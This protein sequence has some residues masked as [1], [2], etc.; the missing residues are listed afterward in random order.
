MANEYLDKDGLKR[1]IELVK[2]KIAELKKKV[3]K[4]V[5][6]GTGTGAIQQVPDGVADG[7][8]FTDK[9]PTATAYGPY[10][11]NDMKK[12]RYL[13]GNLPYG[14]VGNYSSAFG[15]KCLAKGKRSH[16][17]GTTTVS[18]GDY[19]HVEGN[20][21]VTLGANSHAEGKQ[22]TTLGENAHAE[23]FDSFAEG[24][25]SHA[26]GYKTHSK[27]VAS[28]AQ[29]QETK[30]LGDQ[31]SASGYKTIAEGD[32][33]TAQGFG[34]HAKGKCSFVTGEGTIAEY[35]YQTV[36]GRYNVPVTFMPI[37]KGGRAEVIFIVGNGFG[38][39][40]RDNAMLVLDNGEIVTRYIG[41]PSNDNC[42]INLRQFYDLIAKETA[43][44]LKDGN[45]IASVQGGID[46]VSGYKCDFVFGEGL[47]NT[48][49]HQTVFGRF[50]DASDWGPNRPLF[51][52]GNGK[53]D[54]E[55]S[56]AFEVRENGDVYAGGKKLATV[57]EIGDIEAV[58]DSVIALQNSLIGGNV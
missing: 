58:L 21:S 3:P 31:S 34:T 5:E 1:L 18:L 56:N 29:G 22:T 10:I 42:L 44:N 52:I 47:H 38:D 30:A 45:G 15:G 57:D 41:T 36:V 50:N 55:R 7:F 37:S 43:V 26:Q 4:N 20:N 23:G 16:A 9:N 2:S 48:Y 33:S 53:S 19:S 54:S 24:Y 39:G 51:M 32:Y 6:D 40:S 12:G 35:A 27:G 11:D 49:E 46:S 28:H 17:Q 13:Y 14:A 8:D 25:I